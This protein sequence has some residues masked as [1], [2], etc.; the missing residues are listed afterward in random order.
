MIGIWTYLLL[1]VYHYQYAWFHHNKIW[2][3]VYFKKIHRFDWSCYNVLLFVS[4]IIF[5][6]LLLLEL[7]LIL[8]CLL[9][10]YIYECTFMRF[11]LTPLSSRPL[12]LVLNSIFISDR[13]YFQLGWFCFSYLFQSLRILTHHNLSQFLHQLFPL[14][15]QLY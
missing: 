11:I 7:W 1:L 5:N 4:I 10:K 13:I 15:K 14:N 9:I 8:N 2:L 12:I 3:F 6:M